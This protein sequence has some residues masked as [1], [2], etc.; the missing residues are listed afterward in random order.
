MDLDLTDAVKGERELTEGLGF[1]LAGGVVAAR[2]ELRRGY[3]GSWKTALPRRD[4]G[5]HRDLGSLIV[6]VDC[7]RRRERATAGE[8]HAT[9]SFGRPMLCSILCGFWQKKNIRESTGERGR[10]WEREECTDSPVVAGFELKCSQVPAGSGERLRR[11]GGVIQR[12]WRGKWSRRE[13]TFYSRG[14]GSIKAGSEED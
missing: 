13:G 4:E 10:V 12:E 11:P 3:R 6:V 5:Q 9:V 7:L 8:A 14:C 1:Q 2:G